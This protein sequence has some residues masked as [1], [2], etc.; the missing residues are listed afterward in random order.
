M[1]TQAK[2]LTDTGSLRQSASWRWCQGLSIRGVVGRCLVLSC[3]YVARIELTNYK[4]W[5]ALA[6]VKSR[7]VTGWVFNRG[8]RDGNL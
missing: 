1:H 5:G 7:G 3:H 4:L 2:S 6:F 8:N